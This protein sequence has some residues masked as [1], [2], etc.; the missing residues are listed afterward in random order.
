[1]S[2]KRKWE[3]RPLTNSRCT[4]TQKTPQPK[5]RMMWSR[6]RNWLAGWLYKFVA[7]IA[8]RWEISKRR[9]VAAKHDPIWKE[10]WWVLERRYSMLA[11]RFSKLE[12]KYLQA[13]RDLKKFRENGK[14]K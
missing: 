6:L 12:L 10:S 3:P 14:A 1:M 9:R 11:K 2:N 7:R 13:K 8:M 4:P 5:V